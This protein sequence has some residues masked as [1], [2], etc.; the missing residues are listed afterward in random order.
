M[1]ISIRSIDVGFDLRTV[2]QSAV[3]PIGTTAVLCDSPK[4]NG[5]VLARKKAITGTPHE[6]LKKLRGLGYS[7][8]YEKDLVE[9]L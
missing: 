5:Y 7:V 9:A 2:G 1:M 4:R 8:R 6:I 3:L